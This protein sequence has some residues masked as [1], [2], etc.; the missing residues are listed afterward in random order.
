ERRLVG[1]V[2]STETDAI[3]SDDA[4]RDILDD[5]LPV[6]RALRSRSGFCIH[7][8]LGHVPGFEH[9]FSR[10]VR[11][12]DPELYVSGL[13]APRRPFRTHGHQRADA[14]FVSGP[15]RLDSLAQPRLFLGQ[16]LVELLG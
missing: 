3:A 4:S 5:G 11:L 6:L 8:A 13:L 16:L 10:C 9:E 12:F 7:E 1:A 2:R 14:P 15:P